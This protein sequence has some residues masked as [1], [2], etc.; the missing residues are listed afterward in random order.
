ML[1]DQSPSSVLS[2]AFGRHAHLSMDPTG[3]GD[4]VLWPSCALL[5]FFP[6]SLEVRE[7]WKPRVVGLPSFQLGNDNV[8]GI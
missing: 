1:P 6:W 3:A 5:Q 8:C 4:A 7:S 2:C